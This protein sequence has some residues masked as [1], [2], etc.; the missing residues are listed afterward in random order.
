M[1][2][3]PISGIVPMTIYHSTTTGARVPSPI[4]DCAMVVLVVAL[5]ILDC[6]MV[7]LVVALPILDCAM[8]VLVVALLL[9]P[10]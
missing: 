8:V 2:H 7:V 9:R 3:V 4:L 5:P 1:D 10:L 6:A